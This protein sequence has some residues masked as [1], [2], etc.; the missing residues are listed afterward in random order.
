MKL[1]NK[2]KTFWKWFISNEKY[3]YNNVEQNP[4]EIVSLIQAQINLINSDLAFEIGTDLEDGLRDFIISADGIFSNFDDV[5]KLYESSPKSLPKWKLLF[6]RPRRERDNQSIGIEEIDLSYDDIF[7][8]YIRHQ[9][10]LDIDIYIDNYLVD[11]NRFVHIYF[12]LL[13]SLIGEYDAV[14]LITET[15]F[16]DIDEINKLSLHEFREL[17]EVIDNIKEQLISAN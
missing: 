14:M 13:D 4:N 12:L 17:R 5:L 2:Y 6:F 15:R 10:Q 9:N 16:H 11:D 7:F 3:I 1:K 8:T